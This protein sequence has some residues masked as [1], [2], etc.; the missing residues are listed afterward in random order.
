M[1]TASIIIDP[2]MEAALIS[3][4]SACFIETTQCCIPEGHCLHYRN[5]IF[6]FR[7]NIIPR[8]TSRPLTYYLYLQVLHVIFYAFL[9][10]PKRLYISWSSVPPWCAHLIIA[11]LVRRTDEVPH[12]FGLEHF[13]LSYNFLS[14]KP[15]WFPNNLNP[16]FSLAKW[17]RSI[18]TP[19]QT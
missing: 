4:T 11:N 8:F 15:T 5:L 6:E 18:F 2:M 3:E 14:L 9:I 17:E 7:F 19:L 12:R 13:S 1:C 16:Y 10:P